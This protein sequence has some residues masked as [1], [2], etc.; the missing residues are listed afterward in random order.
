MVKIFT[1]KATRETFRQK[2]LPHLDSIYRM[3]VRTCSDPVLAQDLT[4]DTFKE[5]WNSFHRYE[6]DSN[7]KAW[8]FTIFFRLSNRYRHKQ[9]RTQSIALEEIPES[10]L[11]VGPKIE[12][13]MDG[14]L[15]LEVLESLPDHYKAVLALADVEGLSYREIGESLQLPTGTVMSR[16]NRARK[17]LR[18]RFMGRTGRSETA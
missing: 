10:S 4:Q 7:C 1:R 13:E 18:E 2:A 6:P 3:A 8:L 12:D 15:A 9:Y 5:A 17:L 14:K 11:S 16:L